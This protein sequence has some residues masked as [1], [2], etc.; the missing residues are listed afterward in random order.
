MKDDPSFFIIFMLLIIVFS[1]DRVWQKI[2]VLIVLAAGIFLSFIHPDVYRILCLIIA[3]LVICYI[4]SEFIFRKQLYNTNFPL[5]KYLYGKNSLV[6]EA[7]LKEV[8]PAVKIVH[9]ILFFCMLGFVIW[10]IVG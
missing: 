2:I 9:L 5:K 7:S 3:L 4:A 1:S 6:N 8:E 10:L